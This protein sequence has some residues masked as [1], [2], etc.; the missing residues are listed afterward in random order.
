MHYFWTSLTFVSQKQILKYI[1]NRYLYYLCSSEVPYYYLNKED[2]YVA[3]L[4]KKYFLWDINAAR[5]LFF[6]KRNSIHE[7][8]FALHIIAAVSLNFFFVKYRSKSIS[9]IFLPPICKNNARFWQMAH[10]L[11][12]FCLITYVSSYEWI[13]L[14]I[15]THIVAAFSYVIFRCCFWGLF[16]VPREKTPLI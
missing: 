7:L 12:L 5:K 2:I 14:K 8:A 13:R 6:A 16:P 9:R 11:C 10:L 15:H 4:H 1:W 3:M